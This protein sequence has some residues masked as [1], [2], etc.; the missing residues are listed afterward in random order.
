MDELNVRGFF[1]EGDLV[2]A[3]VQDVRNDGSAG[4]HTRSLRYGKL[5]NGVFLA[6]R[7]SGAGA[8][9]GGV[10]RSRRQISTIETQGG[11]GKVDVILGVNG[12][13]FVCAHMETGDE[14]EGAATRFGA[15][16]AK[17]EE[18]A[19]MRMYAS[20]NDHV[21]VATRREI[22]RLGSVVRVLAEKGVR[23]DED[24]VCRGYEVAC[25]IELEKMDVDGKQAPDRTLG[26]EAAEQL[27][28]AV[29]AG[30]RS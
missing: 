28:A 23:V 8:K 7:S 14:E 18:K 16:N 6:V 30:E 13:V 21:D 29:L 11:G 3:E 25:E 2:V 22:A 1:A 9:E 20:A 24:T 12:Y 10:V 15:S 5:R 19:S 17:L 4:L 27:V 26:A